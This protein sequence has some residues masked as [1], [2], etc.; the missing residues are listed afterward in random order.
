MTSV[1]NLQSLDSGPV[2]CP[3]MTAIASGK[4]GV[5]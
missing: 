4:G 3:K 5:G 1:A 2:T